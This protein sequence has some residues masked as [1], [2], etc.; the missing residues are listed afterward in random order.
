MYI[1]SLYT[2]VAISVVLVGGGTAS[3][4]NCIAP[5]VHIMI[6]T[7]SIVTIITIILNLVVVAGSTASSPIY[8]APRVRIRERVLFW[9]ERGGSVESERVKR[10]RREGEA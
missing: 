8:I 2:L 5:F 7:I 9:C 6:I 10:G 4:P 3:G 1:T